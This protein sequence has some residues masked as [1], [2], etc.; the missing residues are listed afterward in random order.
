MAFLGIQQ[1]MSTAFHP[2]TDGQTE[3]VNQVLEAY[4]QEYCNYEQ[5]DWAELL[6]L[7]EYAYNNSFSSATGLSPFYANYGFHPRTNWPTAEQPRNPGSEL[8]AHWLQ[9]IHSQAKDRLTTTRERMAK[10]WDTTRRDGPKFAVGD[11]VML[12]GRNIKTKRA[13][14]KLDAKLYGLSA[15]LTSDVMDARLPS[16]YRPNGG[17]TQRSISLYWSHTAAIP[18]EHLRRWILTPTARDGSPRPSLRLGQTMT[19]LDTTSSW[20]S[21]SD[22]NTAKTPGRPTPILSIHQQNPRRR[23]SAI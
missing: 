8:Y 17:L 19:T 14:R 5:N 2:Q 20:L 9:A 22:T 15:S 11:Y 3:R 7:A 4:L 12:N 13:C 1:C 21:G 23:C 18:T 6:P 10:Y 16:T